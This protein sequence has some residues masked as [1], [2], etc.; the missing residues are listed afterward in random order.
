MSEQNLPS[1]SLS[2]S[3]WAFYRRYANCLFDFTW[4]LISFRV[5]LR[6]V[7]F[8]LTARSWVLSSPEFNV[9]LSILSLVFWTHE[10]WFDYIL[11]HTHPIQTTKIFSNS[12]FRSVST[13]N[14]NKSRCILGA[15]IVSLVETLKSRNTA[16]APNKRIKIWKKAKNGHND[17]SFCEK[18]SI[19]MSLICTRFCC[20]INF[21]LLYGFQS[22]SEM[23]DNISNYHMIY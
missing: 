2:C 15:V 11:C 14:Q 3:F 12:S 19:N 13:Q 8:G 16:V 22:L 18:A 21:I 4:L 17:K 5:T 9:I 23:S 10:T 20:K 6:K 7:I 1:L